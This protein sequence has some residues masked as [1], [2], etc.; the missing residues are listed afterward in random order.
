ML[1]PF[2]Q[3]LCH[4]SFHFRKHGYYSR[5]RGERDHGG[6]SN[7][8]LVRLHVFCQTYVVDG[9]GEFLEDRSKKRGARAQNLP[10]KEGP[11][12]KPD[13]ENTIGEESYNRRAGAN[14]T[15]VF[16]L[17]SLGPTR[18]TIAGSSGEAEGPG[19]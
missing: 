6:G 17:L 8:L 19:E 15:K 7:S 11:K 14:D 5:G 3:F 9:G 16:L 2:P 13:A 4:R 1:E 12:R 18:I 10:K